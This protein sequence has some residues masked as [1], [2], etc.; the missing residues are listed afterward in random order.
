[1]RYVQ[2]VF[3]QISANVFNQK[4]AWIYTA[5]CSDAFITLIVTNKQ[6]TVTQPTI[7]R[8]MKTDCG[9]TLQVI[10]FFCLDVSAVFL[11]YI[12]YVEWK[13]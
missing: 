5:V 4:Q 3:M 11:N 2:G 9:Q 10:Y 1:M 7:K 8:I 12:Y 13:K 6:E